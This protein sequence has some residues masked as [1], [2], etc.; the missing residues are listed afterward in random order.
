MANEIWVGCVFDKILCKLSYIQVVGN[1]II[2]L[3]YLAFFN[4]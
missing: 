4:L 1:E 3:R 2:N